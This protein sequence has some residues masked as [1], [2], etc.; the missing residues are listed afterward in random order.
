VTLRPEL[1]TFSTARHS[2]VFV[3]GDEVSGRQHISC[4]PSCFGGCLRMEMKLIKA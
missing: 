2:C 4:A 1:G 3:F